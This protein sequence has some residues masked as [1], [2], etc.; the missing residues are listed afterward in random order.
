LDGVGQDFDGAGAHDFGGL[1]V[2]QET[3]VGVAGHV[4]GAT[5]AHGPEDI[6]GPIGVPCAVEDGIQTVSSRVLED[7]A[8]AKGHV[9]AA[10]DTQQH[11]RQDDGGA[12]GVALGVDG[13]GGREVEGFDDRDGRVQDHACGVELRPGLPVV[14][15]LVAKV[16]V[17]NDAQ[18]IGGRQVDA[19]AHADCVRVDGVGIQQ[20]V[21]HDDQCRV[22]GHH[23]VQASRTTGGARRA[24]L[25]DGVQGGLRAAQK[26]FKLLV[27]PRDAQIFHV[28][29]NGELLNGGH[30]VG[31]QV[32]VETVALHALADDH[33]R[34]HQDLFAGAVETEHVDQA[35]P[36]HALD[37]QLAGAPTLV[38]VGEV[39]VA[40]CGLTV[41]TR[42]VGGCALGAATSTTAGHPADDEGGR[43]T[44]LAC[45]GDFR[46]PRRGGITVLTERAKAR[47][48]GGT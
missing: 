2:Q 32:K 5:R 28:P 19:G 3:V 40:T 39:V 4:R 13:N 23:R 44:D 21:E 22:A 33:V 27:A 7:L 9:L 18:L 31:A 43:Q 1:V 29:Q 35:T 11:V 45:Q 25:I 15:G 17:G 20:V 42:A 34:V 47:V 12:G 37:D 8:L 30:G 24:L 26:G 38:G 41:G 14:V 16:S 36:E 6:L 10:R 48:L 46:G